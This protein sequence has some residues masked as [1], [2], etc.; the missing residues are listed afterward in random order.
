MSNQRILRYR[1]NDDKILLKVTA[2]AFKPLCVH[3]QHS[4]PYLWALVTD[5]DEPVD[6]SG[7]SVKQPIL[8]QLNVTLTIICTGQN[9]QEA[10]VGEYVGTFEVEWFVGHVYCAVTK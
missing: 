1:L 2:K 6:D 8:S 9:F 7:A 3:M 10:D 5:C 4:N